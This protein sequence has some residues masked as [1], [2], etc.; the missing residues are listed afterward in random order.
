MQQKY[1]TTRE[2]YKTAKRYDHKDFDEFCTRIYMSG[3][4]DGRESVPRIDIKEMLETVSNVKGVGPALAG[5]I[6][7]A[8]ETKLGGAEHGEEDTKK[9]KG[10]ACG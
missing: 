3:Y 7:E 5:R 8:V 1:R 6:R 4:R 10:S 2:V 9:S